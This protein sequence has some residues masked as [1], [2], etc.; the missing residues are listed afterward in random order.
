[1][2]IR[3]DD[4]LCN[5]PAVGQVS[6]RGSAVSILGIFQDLTSF[7]VDPALRGSLDQGLP[8]FPSNMNYAEI[9]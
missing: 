8:E 4:S 5:S 6:Q 1:M 7:I 9:L 3:E 2:D